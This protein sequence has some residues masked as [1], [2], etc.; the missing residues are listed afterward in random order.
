MMLGPSS[1]AATLTPAADG[2]VLTEGRIEG[3]E[4]SQRC[5][6]RGG[7]R[8]PFVPIRNEAVGVLEPVRGSA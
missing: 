1:S 2:S 4:P 7:G 5:P 6:A 3:L 8:V